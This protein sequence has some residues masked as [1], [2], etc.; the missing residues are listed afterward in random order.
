MD[1][2][3]KFPN[4]CCCCLKP[5]PRCTWQV[6]NSKRQKLESGAVLLRVVSVRVP[7]CEQCRRGMRLHNAG[8]VGAALAAGTLALIWWYWDTPKL[9][10]LPVGAVLAL[11]VFFVV[12]IV[13]ESLVGPKR[14]AYL[15]PDGSDITFANAEYQRLYTGASRP[16]R[17]NEADWGDLHWQ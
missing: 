2:Y 1:A 13:L 6:S 15:E 3:T 17:E 7:I 14:V 11:I 4:F 16:G 12:A 5:N 9:S 10:Y 8:V